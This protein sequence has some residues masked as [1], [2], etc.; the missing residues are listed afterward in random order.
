MAEMQHEMAQEKGVMVDDEWGKEWELLTQFFVDDARHCASGFNCVSGMEERFEITTLWSVFFGTEH[1][2]TKCTAVVGRW[3]KAE[4]AED[5]RWA[6]GGVE[7]DGENQGP[8]R[9]HRRGGA[10]GG[11]AGRPEGTGDASEHGRKLERCNGEGRC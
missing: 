3:S 2:A 11:D 8:A 5:R 10:K 7:G 6:E 4:W 9:G 1:R